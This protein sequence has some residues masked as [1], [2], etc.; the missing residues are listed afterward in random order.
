MVT[1][2]T[3][4]QPYSLGLLMHVMAGGAGGPIL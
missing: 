1:A 2:P 4:T 3:S